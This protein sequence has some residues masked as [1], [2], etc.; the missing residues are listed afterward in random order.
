MPETA[1]PAAT[2]AH[3]PAAD[4]P[5]VPGQRPL[6]YWLRHIDGAIEQSM[7]RLFAADALSRRDWQVLNTLSHGPTDTAAL[8]TALAAFLCPEE[9]T[10]RP[11]LEGLAARGWVTLDADG[12]AALTGQGRSAHRRVAAQVAGLRERLAACLTPQELTTLTNLLVRWAGH[13]DT[14]A[15]AR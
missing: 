15:Q 2:P 4:L 13:L 10:V 11:H 14:L 6:G 1:T 5:D 7:A 9:P 8:D 12:R 3:V